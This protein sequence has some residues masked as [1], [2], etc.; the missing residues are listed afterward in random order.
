M[1]LAGER[2]RVL[3]THDWSDAVLDDLRHADP[4]RAGA[5]GSRRGGCGAG[6]DSAT[7]PGRTRGYGEDVPPTRGSR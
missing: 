2:Y 7:F 6:T 5:S 1:R 4:R 3:R